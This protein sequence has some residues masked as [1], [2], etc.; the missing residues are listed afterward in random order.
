MVVLY[1]GVMSYSNQSAGKKDLIWSS[2]LPA[3]TKVTSRY[4]V[5]DYFVGSKGGQGL[6]MWPRKHYLSQER[7]LIIH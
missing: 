1:Y 7:L 3:G 2:T 4:L 5:A 6:P